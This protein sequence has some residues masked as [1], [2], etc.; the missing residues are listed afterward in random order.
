MDTRTGYELDTSTGYEFWIR[1]L[2][3]YC[4]RVRIRLL[5]TSK[6]MSTGYEYEYYEYCTG[7]EYGY[8]YWI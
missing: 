6:Y 1:V 8:E 4:I 5:N 7:Y 3:E 2:N